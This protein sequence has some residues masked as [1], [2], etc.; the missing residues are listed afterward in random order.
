MGIACYKISNKKIYLS[1]VTTYLCPKY[2]TF[3][4]Q[5]LKNVGEDKNRNRYTEKPDFTIFAKLC[6]N[7][8]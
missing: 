7:L 3:C 4:F 8:K 6:F 5:N 1:S 2:I